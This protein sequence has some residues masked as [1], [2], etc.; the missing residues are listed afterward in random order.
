MSTVSESARPTGKLSQT[1]LKALILAATC[2][3]T[4][5]CLVL[6]E[7]F[8]NQNLSIKVGDVSNQE[9]LAP[10]SLTFESEVLTEEARQQA[11]NAVEPVYLPS[12]PAITKSQLEKLNNAIY[13]ISTVR[14]DEHSTRQ[15][16]LSDLSALEDLN[17]SDTQKELMLALDEESWNKIS[18]EANRVLETVLRD[19]LRNDQVGRARA[20]LPALVDFSFSQDQNELIIALVSPL[21]VPTSLYSEEQTNLA[22]EHARTIIEPVSRKIS[23]GEVIVRRGQVIHEAELEALEVYGLA[24]PT[25]QTNLYIRAA[26]MVLLCGSITGLYYNLRSG[27]PFTTLKSILMVSVV[28]VLFLGLARFLVIDRTLIPYIYPVA[29]FGLTL[30]IVFNMEM[31]ILLSVI[32]GVLTVF[33]KSR[34]AELSLLYILPTIAGILTIRRARRIASFLVSGIFIALAGMAVVVI[35][36]LGDSY[37]DLLGFGSLL[38][39]AALNG[40]ASGSVTLILQHIFASL[41]DIPTALQLLD[42]SRPDHPLLQLILREAPGS[43]QHSLLVSNLA[44][45]AAEA[46]GA[47]R[48]LVRVGTLFHDSGKTVNPAYFIENQLKE[49]IDSHD[50]ADPA[51]AAATII[52]H[53][54]DGVALAKHYRLPSRV[55]DFILEHHGTMVTRYQYSQALAQAENPADVDI[56]R[57]TYPGPAPRSRETAILMLADGTE[58]RAR[59]NTPR[60]DEEIRRVIQDTIDTCQEAGQLDNTDLTLRDLRTIADSFFATLKRSYHPRIQYPAR[61][62]AEE[63]PSSG[64]VPPTSEN[65]Q[66]KE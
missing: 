5:A 54:Y 53:V 41:L 40:L 49:K 23:A 60:T 19:S 11:A 18:T 2:L 7:I 25:D 48:L 37:T 4:F 64:G 17:L 35:F 27:Q 30:S 36:R 20:N 38:A 12:D 8:N 55:I 28:F 31:S 43:Y 1:A 10:S 45:Q 24:E 15:Q 34:E 39:A 59:A 58:A 16:K 42:I 63:A 50:A 14:Q 21:I 46:I 9:I 32:L 44:E 6:P 26:V 29:A 52:Q 65:E 13:F 51:V 62:T 3:L 47:D 61:T 57:F 33:G 56:S 66:A 22:R